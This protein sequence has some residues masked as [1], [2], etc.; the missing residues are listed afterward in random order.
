MLNL[1]M[2]KDLKQLTLI[3]PM[4]AKFVDF[5]L[6]GVLSDGSKYIADLTDRNFVVALGVKIEKNFTALG[7]VLIG[8]VNGH[9][10]CVG[11]G[12]DHLGGLLKPID[13][14]W[15]F[16]RTKIRTRTNTRQRR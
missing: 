9:R 8:R 4:L 5:R 14:L 3:R 16:E 11:K 13:S 6:S 1:P 10:R 7:Q 2:N 12:V 15:R